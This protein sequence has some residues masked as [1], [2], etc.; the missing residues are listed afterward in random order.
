MREVEMIFTNI[1]VPTDLS[2]KSEKALNIA[3]NMCETEDHRIYLLH[4]IETLQSDEDSE[5]QSFYD[6][7]RD[8][9]LRKMDMM[10]EKYEEKGDIIEREIAYGN[11]S[12][13]IIR[14]ANEYH[15]DLIVLSSHKIENVE[16]SEGWATISYKVGILSPC[17]VLLVK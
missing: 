5:F 11:R 8:R 2:Q 1:L 6:K 14:F 3:F 12:L 10:L 15:I 13:E 7:L 9:A 16:P 4:V 17:P